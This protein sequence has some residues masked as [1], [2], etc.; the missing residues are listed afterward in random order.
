MKKLIYTLLVLSLFSLNSRAS[1]I[2]NGDFETFQLKGKQW[3]VL[4]SIDGWT[5]T[6]GPG[7]EIQRNTVVKAQS[8]NQYVELDSHDQLRQGGNSALTQSVATDIGHH[9]L[10][11]FYYLPRT[12]HGNNDNGL[13][14]YWDDLATELDN[15]DPVNAIFAI[16]NMTRK[17]M[18]EWTQYTVKLQATSDLM[19]LSFGG[20]GLNNTLG[21]FID[22]VSLNKIPEPGTLAM[23][24]MALAILLLNRQSLTVAIPRM[25][26]ES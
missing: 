17:D 5:T 25:A 12:N 14:V 15:F 11:S 20:T 13:A 19:A 18:R 2:T 22:N 21:A 4:P 1:L 8:G 6:M 3:R 24:G 26:V 10:L 16:D 9:Y 7:I 23:L